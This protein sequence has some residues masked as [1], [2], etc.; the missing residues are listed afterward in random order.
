MSHHDNLHDTEVDDDLHAEVDA[1]LVARRTELD[2]DL[3][4]GLDIETGLQDVLIGS[5]HAAVLADVAGNLDLEAGLATIAPT[6]ASL[7]DLPDH[8]TRVTPPPPPS[9]P[10]DA[11]T[12]AVAMVVTALPPVQR[13]ALRRH[14]L[15]Q[16]FDLAAACVAAQ[17]AADIL[18]QALRSADDPTSSAH[19]VS[20]LDQAL[21]TVLA[22]EASLARSI[23]HA[24]NIALTPGNT[25]DRVLIAA[26]VRALGDAE[27]LALARHR[28]LA[29][30]VTRAL[31]RAGDI[32]SPVPALAT[33]LRHT[34]A[35]EYAQLL[36]W[37][38]D[39]LN[40][41]VGA[42]LRDADLHGVPLTGI[43]WSGYTTQW[44][45]SWVDQITRES[46]PIEGTDGIFVV[47]G[48]ATHE[49]SLV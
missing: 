39:A 5:R 33:A 11:A 16:C 27:A 1:W 42:D 34:P 22:H 4:D 46:E 3:A 24:R 15:N 35:E 40:D 2:A 48:G 26:F 37:L 17:Y 47:R 10:V 43:R 20:V 7:P 32:R 38:R 41:L 45:A 8:G 30:A 14:P 19:I 23:A 31:A 49:E 28:A 9:R 13:V 44:P 29:Q 36:V 6:A 18:G 25:S 21:Y 12:S